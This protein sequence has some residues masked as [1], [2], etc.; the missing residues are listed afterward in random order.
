M[1]Q[2]D[3]SCC[4]NDLHLNLSRSIWETPKPHSYLKME[5]EIPHIMLSP[6]VMQSTEALPNEVDGDIGT[7]PSDLG[8]GERSDRAPDLYRFSE[9]LLHFLQIHLLWRP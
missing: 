1:S 9:H 3:E 7:A 8:E 2:A 6:S 5:L 4:K